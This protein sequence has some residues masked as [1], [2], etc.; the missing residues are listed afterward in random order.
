[1][2]P[3]TFL[4]R[5]KPVEDVKSLASC[6][7]NES[8]A[9]STALDGI[10]HGFATGEFGRRIEVVIKTSSHGARDITH[11]REILWSLAEKAVRVQNTLFL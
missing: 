10:F 3:E 11:E 7:K 5:G 2:E 9:R 6:T 1:M 8:V 4:C